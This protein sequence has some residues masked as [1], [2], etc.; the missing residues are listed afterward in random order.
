MEVSRF[1][2]TLDFR[3]WWGEV[4][5][6]KEKN[7]SQ[8]MKQCPSPIKDGL[9]IWVIE[10]N[11]S[12]TMVILAIYCKALLNRCSNMNGIWEFVIWFHLFC[13]KKL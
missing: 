11:K 10:K 5:S 3:I 9:Q 4:V 8:Q 12:T 7:P 1:K 2:M 13:C 6:I